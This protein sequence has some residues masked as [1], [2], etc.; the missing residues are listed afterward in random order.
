MRPMCSMRFSASPTT[1]WTTL[2]RPPEGRQRAELERIREAALG[3][4]E[5][6]DPVLQAF[7]EISEEHGIP[8]REVREFVGAMER[9]VSAERYETHDELGEYLRGRRSRSRT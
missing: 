9:D 3:E 6:D 7:G 8:A 1:S 4:R 2:I 5:A